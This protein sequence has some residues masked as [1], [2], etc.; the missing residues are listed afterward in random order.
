MAQHTRSHVMGDPS[1]HSDD[2][3]VNPQAH[4]PHSASAQLC[5]CDRDGS[6]SCFAAELRGGADIDEVC[7][8]LGI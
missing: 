1:E 5:A 7:K 4:R 2:E 3:P 8:K 6:S